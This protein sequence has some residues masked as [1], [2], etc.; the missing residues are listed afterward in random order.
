MVQVL[1]LTCWS[2]DLRRNQLDQLHRQVPRAKQLPRHRLRHHQAL[3]DP[4][5]RK[6]NTEL[7]WSCATWQPALSES[8]TTHSISR[9]AKMRKHSSLPSHRAR[10]KQTA[11]TP[12]ALMAMVH[13]PPCLAA[14]ENTTDSPGTKTTTNWHSSAIRKMLKQSNRSFA[15]TIGSGKIRRPPRSFQ[16]LHLVSARTLLSPNARI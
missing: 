9:S 12:L 2:G 11:S 1:W 10:K 3:P 6:R 8:L 5:Q 16:S 7:S 14:K 15:S 13:L 4:D